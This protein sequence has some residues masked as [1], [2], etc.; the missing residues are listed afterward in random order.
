MLHATNHLKSSDPVLAAIIE[1]AGPCNIKY[2]EPDFSTLVKSIANQQISG[3]AARS[4]LNRLSDACG[5]EFTPERIL[6]LS[7]QKMRKCGF[8]AQKTAYIR[9]LARLT[10]AGKVDYQAMHAMS[11]EEVIAA[12][13]QVKGIGVW[14]AQMF[15][16][17]ALKRENVLPVGDLGVRAAIKKAYKTRGTRKDPYPKARQIQKLAAKWQPYCSIATWYLWRS[18]EGAAE[19]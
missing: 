17:F 4:I 2:L 9:D 7:P 1:R 19:L 11:D 6:K 12:L 8:S 18:L 10:K 5:G 15:L 3:K 14:T 13:T 16:M